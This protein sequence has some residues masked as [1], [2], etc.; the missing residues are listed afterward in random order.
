MKRK[1]LI[2]L[3]SAMCVLISSVGFAQVMENMQLGPKAG[4]HWPIGDYGDVAD[5][6][7][8]IGGQLKAPINER[9]SW[10]VHFAY[11]TADG[12][13]SVG[14]TVSQD[15]DV[16]MFEIYP[17]VDY[18]LARDYRV[19]E[20]RMDFFLRGGLGLNFWEV[21]VNRIQIGPGAGV[22][23][24][25]EDD[26]DLMMAIGGGVNFLGNFEALVLYN[27]ILTADFEGDKDINE[28]ITLT[29]G[30]N[31]NLAVN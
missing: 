9:W 16:S 26:M 10:G 25:S 5:L 12:D 29:I 8:T 15:Y 3:I 18:F 4:L 22:I 30:Y 6:G 13:E 27:R 1:G 19:Q 11:A 20:S 28:Y 14:A 2:I 24:R 7:Y 23:S 17:F 31:F 21:D